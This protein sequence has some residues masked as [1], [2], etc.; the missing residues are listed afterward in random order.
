MKSDI[1]SNI[2]F[3]NVA[4]TLAI[5]SVVL[6]HLPVSRAAY[7]F[8]NHFHL[9]LFFLI[10]GYLMAEEGSISF[11]RWTGKK[12][13]TILAP[14]YLFAVVAWLFW[15]GVGRKYGDAAASPGGVSDYLWGI[16][17]AIP[18]KTYLGFDFPLWFLPTLFVAEM[19]FYGIR[20]IA[21]RYAF[22]L[23]AL[24]FGVGIWLNEIHLFRLPYGVDVSLFAL[25]FLQARQWLKEKNRMD[26]YIVRPPLPLKIVLAALLLGLTWYIAAANRSSE[27]I[28]MAHRTFNHY[29]L[30]LAGAAAGS[31]GLL[32]LSC[33][34][35]GNRFFTFFG[36]NTILIL[37][38][39]LMA[40]SAI[41]GVQVIVLGI[42]LEEDT[43]GLPLL[44]AA[45][46]FAL[47][48]PVIYAVNRYASFLLGRKK[49]IY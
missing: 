33:S 49:G 4:R 6:G 30:Y 29:A 7:D 8:I 16:I 47:L 21:G 40:L 41:K 11:R 10:S 45:L 18:S 28:A 5:S 42:P 32:Y 26:R 22:A 36:R 38:F 1:R 37:G 23:S 25:P 2:A 31:L 24:G 20:R 3:V 13:R 48:A 46:T 27:P 35:K 15:Y 12:V 34:C 39:H 19:L 17:L 9:P 14:Y 43:P 44:Y